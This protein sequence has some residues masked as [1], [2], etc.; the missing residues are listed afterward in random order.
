MVR[1]SWTVR[2]HACTSAYT[3]T[4]PSTIAIARTIERRIETSGAPRAVAPVA[5]RRRHAEPAQRGADLTDV[6][7]RCQRDRDQRRRRR[8]GR[9]QRR[10]GHVGDVTVVVQRADDPGDPQA[11]LVAGAELD[12]E[13]LAGTEP[14]RLRQTL[15]DLDLARAVGPVAADQRGRLEPRQVPRVADHVDRLAQRERVDALDLVARRGRLHPRD[16]PDRGGIV[17]RQRGGQLVALAERARIGLQRAQLG[18]QREQQ[19]HEP[20]RQA[21]R[22]RGRQQPRAPGERPASRRARA[23]PARERR[24]QAGDPARR[25]AGDVGAA[26]QRD[27]RSRRRAPGRPRGSGDRHRH[28]QQPAAEQRQRQR[29]PG[30]GLVEQR[31]QPRRTGRRSPALRPRTRPRPPAPRSAPTPASGWT[32]RSRPRRRSPA[33]RRSS[34]AAAGPRPAPTRRAS[35]PRSRARSATA[36]PAGR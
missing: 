18:G 26:Q 6:G 21:Q 36:R 9:Q 19:Q 25:P 13:R 8:V 17:R 33:A 4:S 10:R 1:R 30:R 32:R 27:R 23:S 22:G 15:A 3:Q 7:A 34:S 2:A 31:Q 12:R 20:D 14:E 28:R 16:P 29:P 35:R 5:G 11:Q 24:S